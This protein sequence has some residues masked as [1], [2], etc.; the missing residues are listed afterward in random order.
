MDNMGLDYYLKSYT[1][2]DQAADKCVS[3]IQANISGGKITYK[4]IDILKNYP[5]AE[6]VWIS[7]LIQDTF[8]Y[9]IE[10]YGQ[11]F[12]VI[13]FWKCPLISDFTILGTLPI[14]EYLIFFW[15]QRVTHLWDMSKNL[16]LKGISFDDFTRMHTLSEIPLAP[17]LEE[18]Y[19]G[20]KVW[21]KYIVESLTPLAHAKTLKVLE[22]TA[23]KIEDNDITPL[24][25]ISNL[26]KLDFPTNLFTTEQ[27][28]WLT[29]NIKNVDSSVLGP[30]KKLKSPLKFGS[31]N[32][33]VLV[34]G[35]RKPFLD[36]NL[37]KDRLQKYMQAFEGLVEKYRQEKGR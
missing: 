26:E 6:E 16:N 34:I 32:A 7:G 11:Q 5:E 20:D 21:N 23:K 9:F 30:Y 29:A 25:E 31:K 35:K 17:S 37:D 33:D 27:V 13:Q 4:D 3:L 18:L 24:A 19:F 14:A 8:E 15:N 1:L 22:F 36:S 2:R 28:A 12:K 10:N